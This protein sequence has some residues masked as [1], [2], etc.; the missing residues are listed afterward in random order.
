[1]KEAYPNRRV[2]RQGTWL[3][4][5]LLV[6]C[7]IFIA[8]GIFLV[9]IDPLFHSAC[10][11][12]F[13]K[14][15]CKAHQGEAKNNV[16]QI[17]RAQRTYY[18]RYAK[19]TSSQ[20]ILGSLMESKAYTYS[21]RITA[22]AAFNYAIPRQKYQDHKGYVGAVFVD[23]QGNSYSIKCKSER[24]GVKLLADPIYHNGVLACGTGTRQV[25]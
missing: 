11:D 17:N 9:H 25:K 16:A 8:P 10:E 2:A 3:L 4:Y 13:L 20:K 23:S 1:M 21:I 12:R 18:S 19:F 5:I 14:Q 15:N 22:R 6:P 24:P 7:L